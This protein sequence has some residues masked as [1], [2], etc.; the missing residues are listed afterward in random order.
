M[1]PTLPIVAVPLMLLAALLGLVVVIQPPEP[2]AA[3]TDLCRVDSGRLDASPAG[4]DREQ[5][6]N[7][8]TII[9][10]ARLRD[11]PARGM[12]VAIAAAL[13]ES[14]LRNLSGGD[15]DSAGLFQMRPSTGWGSWG[16]V[17]DP[18]YAATAF[19]GGPDVP[20]DNPGLFDVPGWEQMPI[21]EAAQAVERSAYP[22]AYTKWADDAAAVVA[23]ITGE[24]VDCTTTTGTDCPPS[25]RSV[26]AG[27]MPD[28][29]LVVRCAVAHFDI[30]SIGGLATGGHVTGSDHYTG[31]AVD[32]MIDD[33]S[34]PEGVAFGDR[35]AAYFL[36]DPQAFGITYLI[37]RNRIWS[38]ARGGWRPYAHPDGRT[39]PT[40]L[41]MDHLHV[42]VAGNS[43]TGLE[44]T[45]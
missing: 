42:S 26:E 16:Q 39:D 25:G 32:L 27:L 7:A 23:A 5:L 18:V 37:W 1:K 21:A 11:V 19:F 38:A 36:A 10:V 3:T 14:S 12:V 40:A 17:T 30:A 24:A 31:R 44:L 20:P 33:W 41:H 22:D 6:G 28:A 4:V 8:A 29:Q 34:T 15:R 2:A 35:V 43:A 45:P 13:Q 9:Q